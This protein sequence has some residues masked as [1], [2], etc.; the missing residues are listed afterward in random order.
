MK[1]VLDKNKTKEVS[2]NDEEIRVRLDW[3]FLRTVLM[4]MLAGATAILPLLCHIAKRNIKRLTQ[5][6]KIG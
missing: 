6:F 4:H 5:R 1:K 3:D 2:I